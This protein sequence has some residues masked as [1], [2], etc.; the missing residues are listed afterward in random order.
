MIKQPT[1]LKAPRKKKKRITRPPRKRRKMKPVRFCD[2]GNLLPKNDEL[3]RPCQ[4][5]LPWEMRRDIRENVIGALET[6]KSSLEKP[7]VDVMG[8]C[9]KYGRA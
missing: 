1:P 7:R 4:R 9:K 2:C 8:I 5:D 3:C 6:A